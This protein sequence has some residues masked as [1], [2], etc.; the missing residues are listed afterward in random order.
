M[1][2]PGPVRVGGIGFDIHTFI[3]SCLAIL[4]GLQTVTFSVM[5]R[6]F[7]ESRGLVPRSERYSP[8]LST[9]TMERMLLLALAMGSAGLIGMIYCVMT[10]ANTGFGPLEYQSLLRILTLSTTAV[11]AA[12]QMAFAAFLLGVMDVGTRQPH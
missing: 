1:L 7:G 4:V 9:I 11:A 8:L 2:L 10:W 12:L 5:A 3:V 6:K